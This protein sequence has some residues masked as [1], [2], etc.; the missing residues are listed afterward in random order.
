M[1]MRSFNKPAPDHSR[2]PANKLLG[3]GPR[4]HVV[5]KT[6]GGISLSEVHQVRVGGIN[7]A[8]H[9]GQLDLLLASALAGE[10]HQDLVNCW[11]AMGCDADQLV[12]L[13]FVLRSEVGLKRFG[14]RSTRGIVLSIFCNTKTMMHLRALNTIRN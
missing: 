4:S 1:E 5:K 6:Y 11:A 13:V 8:K 3:D 2:T 12:V 14:D 10:I 9:V 7:F